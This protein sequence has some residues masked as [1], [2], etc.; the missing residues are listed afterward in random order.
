MQLR[1][2]ADD[3]RFLPLVR[4]RLGEILTSAGH[5]RWAAEECASECNASGQ[6]FDPATQYLRVRGAGSLQPRNAAVLRELTAW[7]DAAA[8]AHDVPPR[9]FL[10]DEVML[11]L[12]RSPVKSV[13]KLDRVRGLPRPVE[14]A[15]GARIVELTTRAMAMA[16][17]EL[18][19]AR[20]P[21]PPPRE[22]FATDAL[23]AA[24]QCICAGR[25]IDPAIA[26]DRQEV[27]E[28]VRMFRAGRDVSSHRLMTGCAGSFWG[29][30]CWN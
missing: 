25:S 16:A 17:D 11:D 6:R 29:R 10:R 1:Y 24:A 3:V 27:G 2:A 5:D 19:A 7:R 23:W 30:G 14:H 22:R 13:E 8:R 9:T 26:A 20:D 4:A 21:E 18:P 15:H 12:A 28:F